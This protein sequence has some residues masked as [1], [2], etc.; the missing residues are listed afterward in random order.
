MLL[1][2]LSPGDATGRL[3]AALVAEFLADMS[4]WVILEREEYHL[5]NVKFK[6]SIL[7]LA[8]LVFAVPGA[9]SAAHAGNEMFA[10]SL[11]S[12]AT[13]TVTNSSNHSNSSSSW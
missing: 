7:R 8:S 3:T 9:L 4:M 5:C 12:N 13:W 10:L 11:V 2:K 6:W 1:R